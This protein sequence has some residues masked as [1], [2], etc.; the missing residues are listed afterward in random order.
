MAKIIL[1][2]SIIPA[3]V[4][5]PQTLVAGTPGA[6]PYSHAQCEARRMSDSGCH[7][8]IVQAG[9]SAQSAPSTVLT[10]SVK[11]GTSI[12]SSLPIKQMWYVTAVELCTMDDSALELDMDRAYDKYYPNFPCNP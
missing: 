8:Q 12:P 2:L 3:L 10:V 4:A 5:M 7:R 9:G 6:T 1:S 11:T